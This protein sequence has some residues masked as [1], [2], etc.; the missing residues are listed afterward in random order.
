M[1][2]TCPL[3]RSTFDLTSGCKISGPEAGDLDVVE[4]VAG[5]RYAAQD[6]WMPASESITEW[7]ADFHA[8]MLGDRLRMTAFRT[9]IHEVVTPGSVVVDLGTGT[10]IL[11]QWALEAGA[12]RVYGIDFN[13]AVL[14]TAVQRIA[15]AGLGE[16]F[17]PVHGMSFDIELP[18]RAGVIISE[19]LGNIADNE[20]C[21]RILA[22]ARTRWLTDDGV[23]LPSTVESYLVP[24]AAGRAHRSVASGQTRGGTVAGNRFGTYYDTILPLDT[25]LATPRLARRYEFTST[26]TDEYTISTS[27]LVGHDGVFTGFKGYFVAD[28]SPTVTM[29]ISGDDIT[30]RLT[31]DSW[32]H[33]YLPVETP[34]EVWAGDRITLTF[35]RSG[36][37]DS[38]SF[39]QR[40]RWA[41]SVVRDTTV[42]AGFDHESGTAR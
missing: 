21:V 30:R 39:G 13:E 27:F 16:R 36:A 38:G 25:Y 3:H 28:L 34:V 12:A 10:G 8:L 17:R 5:S 40:Y 26:E 18:E 11:A 4:R 19:T 9:A 24:V 2:V 35:S 20:G 31:S 7:D 33:C 23:M 42:L 14:D 29:D 37:S 22:D 15:K 32:K 41:G 6:V 1:R